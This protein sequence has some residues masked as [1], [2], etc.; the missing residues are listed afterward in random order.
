MGGLKKKKKNLTWREGEK[1]EKPERLTG[2]SA[3]KDEAEKVGWA[4][5]IWRDGT[6]EIQSG[7]LTG[8]KCDGC[9]ETGRAHGG[10][11]SINTLPTVCPLMHDEPMGDKSHKA[12]VHLWHWHHRQ[13]LCLRPVCHA[14]H[15]QTTTLGN[16]ADNTTNTVGALKRKRNTFARQLNRG[17]QKPEISQIHLE[18]LPIW[19]NSLYEEQRTEHFAINHVDDDTTNTVGVLRNIWI[20]ESNSFHL[21]SKNLQIRLKSSHLY[22]FW[23][24]E[25]WPDQSTYFRIKRGGASAR[26]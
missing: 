26:V 12:D 25:I 5:S 1:E 11:Q 20:R 6:A 8:K 23:P 7:Y 2:G 19:S 17:H 15:H 3:G 9:R 21:K 24:V 4:K 14:L 16:H 10:I 13:Q 22:H 18:K